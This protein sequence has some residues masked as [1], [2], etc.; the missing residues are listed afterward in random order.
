MRIIYSLIV[1]IMGIVLLSVLTVL[2]IYENGQTQLSFRQVNLSYE[3]LGIIQKLQANIREANEGPI[4]YEQNISL[5]RKLDSLTDGQPALE[6]QVE[7]L[8]TQLKA[9]NTPEEFSQIAEKLQL[10]EKAQTDDLASRKAFAERHNQLPALIGIGISIFSILIFI[11]AFYF[12]NAELRKSTH[13]NNELEAKNLQLEKYT[14][15]LRSFTDIASHDMQE[16]LRKIEL[17]VSLIE[18]REKKGMSDKALQH[19]EKI[20]DSVARLRQQFFSVLSF[21]LADET[22]NAKQNID[23]NEVLQETIESMKLYIKDTNA[24]IVSDPLPYV[25]GNRP[26]LVQLFQN[27]LSNALKYK[28]P[29]VLPELIIRYELIAG[30]D[31]TVRELRKDNN[32]YRIMFQDNGMGFEQKYVDKIFELFQ[33]HVRTGNDGLGIGLSLCRK[34]AENHSG[35][36]TAESQINKGS[37]FSF[38][39]PAE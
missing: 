13:L 25:K 14:R 20:K 7:Q 18:E 26:Q 29:D 22:R 21:T 34:I 11:I 33:R 35:T 4:D 36:M 1:F 24:V 6:T 3:A 9:N 10:I 38:Y 37:L 39:I 19:F 30:K 16:P 8:K 12:T 27:L 2:L 5:I 32:Y 17:F 23:L 28:R 15:E 31:I